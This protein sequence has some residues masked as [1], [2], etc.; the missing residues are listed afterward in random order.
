MSLG[1]ADTSL[2]EGDQYVYQENLGGLYST[3]NDC[4][5]MV[6]GDIGVIISAHV[7]NESLK[8]RLL[9]KSQELHRYIR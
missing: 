2:L 1:I 7:M 3:C 4:D 6:F 5:Y 8:K 9:T